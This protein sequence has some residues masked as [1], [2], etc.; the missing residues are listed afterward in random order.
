MSSFANAAAGHLIY[1]IREET[2]I[3]EE[4]CG[5]Q[6]IDADAQILRLENIIR[7]CI[8]PR[9]PGI[10]MRAIPLQTSTVAIIIRIPRSWALPHVAKFEGH[11]RFYSRNSAGK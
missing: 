5:L 4:L 7:D 8:E 2:G 9:I 1:G 10:H 3:P 6:N 11:W